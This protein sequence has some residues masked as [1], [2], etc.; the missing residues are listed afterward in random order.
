LAAE[1]KRNFGRNNTADTRLVQRLLAI[2]GFSP[3]DVDG[4]IGAR[5]RAAITT[6]L[7]SEGIASTVA[8]NP[9]LLEALLAPPDNATSRGALA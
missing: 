6:F 9:G 2:R 3:G 1:A 8:I 5:T 7:E 4:L